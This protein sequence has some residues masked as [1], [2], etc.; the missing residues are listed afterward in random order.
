ME[1]RTPSRKVEGWIPTAFSRRCTA[2]STFQRSAARS[3]ATTRRSGRADRSRHEACG[4]GIRRGHPR[5]S[6]QVLPRFQTARWNGRHHGAGQ[7]G[8]LASQR[9]AGRSS[10]ERVGAGTGSLEGERHRRRALAGHRSHSR[11]QLEQLV[12]IVRESVLSRAGIRSSHSRV[13][14]QAASGGALAALADPFCREDTGRPRA[15]AGHR[16]NTWRRSRDRG[17]K[18]HSYAGPRG[19]HQVSRQPA[20]RR[21]S[22]QAKRRPI[23]HRSDETRRNQDIPD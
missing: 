20:Y 1:C 17:L 23:L 10:D 12:G 22:R 7:P 9:H 19:R 5:A 21:L 3:N 11:S 15:P 4:R 8:F 14:P 6:D 13:S 18:Q 16:R 2:T